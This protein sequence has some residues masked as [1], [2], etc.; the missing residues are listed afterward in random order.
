MGDIKLAD[1]VPVTPTPPMQTPSARVL[2]PSVHLTPA[3]ETKDEAVGRRAAA[4]S[5]RTFMVGFHLNI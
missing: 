3:A 2:G 4:L 5:G 1:W